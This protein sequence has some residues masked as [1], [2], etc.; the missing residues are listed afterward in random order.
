MWETISGFAGIFVGWFLTFCT[1]RKQEKERTRQ[2]RIT[3]ANTLL[4]EIEMIKDRV[5]KVN[6]PGDQPEK[7]KR[8]YNKALYHSLH[9]RLGL[10]QTKTVRALV[11]FYQGIERIEAEADSYNN[12]QQA[13]ERK[14]HLDNWNNAVNDAQKNLLADVERDL[15]LEV[16]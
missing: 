13:N 4:A 9:P 7:P 16:N 8:D 2:E 10:F 6:A 3:S 12:A 11:R 15:K 14:K 5:M 1:T